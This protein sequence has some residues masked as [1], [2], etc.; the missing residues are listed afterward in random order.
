MRELDPDVE[1]AVKPKQQRIILIG[2]GDFL[3]NRFLHNGANLPLGLNLLDWLSGEENFLNLRFTETPDTD[4]HLSDKTLA[5]MGIFFLFVLPGSCF[6]IAA[7]I[8]WTRRNS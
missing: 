4:L 6:L 8:W 2:D 3:S 7:R 5:W 1:P